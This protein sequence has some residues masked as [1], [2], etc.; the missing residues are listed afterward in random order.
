MNS[1]D[2]NN[3]IAR[4]MERSREVLQGK[5]D[6]YSP[7]EDKLEQ[8]K[9][10]AKIQDIT[11]K[12]AL[13]GMMVKHTTSI[14]AMINDGKVYSLAQWDEKIGDHLNYLLLLSALVEEETAVQRDKI[15]RDAN[16]IHAP[17]TPDYEPKTADPN[18]ETK[19]IAIANYKEEP[20]DES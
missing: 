5:N 7:N 20:D 8:F 16:T 18:T 19:Y 4:Q 9:L 12:E 3:A 2:F 14:Y 1:H 13:G 15:V 10:A 17:Q 11:P 6:N